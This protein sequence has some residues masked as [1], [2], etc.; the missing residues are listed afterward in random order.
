LI[1]VNART[2]MHLKIPASTM[3]GSMKITELCNRNVVRAASTTPV[4]E[5]ARLMRDR[6]VGSV[7]VFEQQNGREVPIGIVTDRDIT[8][9]VVALGLDPA[10]IEVGD[11]MAPRFASVDADWAVDEVVELMEVKGVRRMVVTDG[12]GSLY[13]IVAADDAVSFLAE[14]LT[15]LAGIAVAGRRREMQLRQAA[16]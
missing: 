16:G 8:V 11:I 2:P 1:S 15:R 3:G 9:A 13:G 10:V 7:V 4:F 6:H 14:Q 12:D 5:A